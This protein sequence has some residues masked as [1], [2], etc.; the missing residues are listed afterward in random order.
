VNKYKSV[1]SQTFKCSADISKRPFYRAANAVFE[2]SGCLAMHLNT[3]FYNLFQENACLWWFYVGAGVQLYPRFLALH[4]KFG[5]MQ[6]NILTVNNI[7]VCCVDR[8]I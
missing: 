4:P 3:L 1:R 7:L 5:M 2:K 8:N 6:Q